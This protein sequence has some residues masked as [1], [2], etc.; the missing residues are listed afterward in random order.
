MTSCGNDGSTQLSLLSNKTDN[1]MGQ[2]I[3]DDI[4]PLL[5]KYCDKF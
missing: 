3:V 2:N 4:V 5:V 1:V